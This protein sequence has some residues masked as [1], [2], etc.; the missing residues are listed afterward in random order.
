MGSYFG[1]L[2]GFLDVRLAKA[3]DV[4][5]LANVL[6]RLRDGPSQPSPVLEQL[7]ESVEESSD[8]VKESRDHVK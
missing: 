7:R 8:H 5:V 2:V 1:R 4:N 6:D 3:D